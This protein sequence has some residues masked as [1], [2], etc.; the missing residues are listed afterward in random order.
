MQKYAVLATAQVAVGAAAIF[1]R[2]ALTGAEPLAVSA[3]RL[4]I[5][6]VVLLAIAIVRG[7]R[8]RVASQERWIFVTAGVALAM[9][10]AGWIWS[11]EYTSVAISTLLVSTTPIWTAL[12]DA[13]VERKFLS[14]RSWAAFAAGAVGLVLV[15]GAGSTKPP[16]PGHAVLGGVLALVGALAI[17]AYFILI[18][19]VR[20]RYDTRTIVTRTY[21]WAA[22]VL[23]LAAAVA[24]QTPPALSD[25]K[26][27]GGI[28]A[29]ALISQLMGHT[30]L[31]AALRWFSPSAV[32][33][34]SLLEPVVAAVLAFFIF[35]EGLA[36]AAL[37]G[38]LLLL[39]A[40]GVFLGEE[41]RR[42]SLEQI[43]EEV[44]YGR[45]AAARLA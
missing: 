34:S 23:V 26:A 39:G 1:A 6:A 20:A 40:I 4:V 13:G 30:A 32:A 8:T 37:A 25:G 10:F 21:A 24:H 14:A 18:R 38:G 12:Y 36:P 22:V 28:L 9:H 19:K 43:G 2:F 42:R 29:M 45:S 33:F 35:G 41:T 16:V 17:G 5:A 44:L 3:A 7:D 15:V 11:L 27:W 31:N